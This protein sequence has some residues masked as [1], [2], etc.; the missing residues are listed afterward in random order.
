MTG[1][2]GFTSGALGLGVWLVLT[3]LAASVGAQFRPGAWYLQL[4]K[5]GWTPLGYLFAPVWTTLYILMALAAWMV[6][7]RGGFKTQAVPLSLFLVQLFFNGIWSWL[8][9]GLHSTVL[10]LIDIALLWAGLA[11]TVAMF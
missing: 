10:G 8:F 2:K 6:W 1:T 11:S 3:F 9:F 7:R 5:P 4:N